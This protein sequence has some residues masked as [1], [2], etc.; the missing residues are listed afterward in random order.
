[1]RDSSRRISLAGCSAHVCATAFR[2]AYL[3]LAMNSPRR[4]KDHCVQCSAQLI[5]EYIFERDFVSLIALLV[6]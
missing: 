4:K 3:T 2:I 6:A 5:F 1:M